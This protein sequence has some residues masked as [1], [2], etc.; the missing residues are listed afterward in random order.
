MADSL[1]QRTSGSILETTPTP[2]RQDLSLAWNSP[3]R[4]GLPA[5]E[6]QGPSCLCFPS[7]RIACADYVV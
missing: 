5:S 3:I 4:S 1:A 7:T 6:P 2:W